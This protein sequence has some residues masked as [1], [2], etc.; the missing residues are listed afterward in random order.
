MV[1]LSLDTP[2]LAAKYDVVGQRQ[3]SHGKLLINDLGI[4]AGEHVLDVGTGTGLLAAYVANIVGPSGKVAA[5]DP[6]PLR[7]ELAKK[8][9]PAQL[10]VSVGNAEDLSAFPPGSFDVVY[11]NSVIHWILDKPRVLAEIRRVLKPGGRVGFTTAAKDR[12]HDVE[13]IRQQALREAGLTERVSASDGIPFKV[14]SDDVRK[15]FEQGG[16]R[17]KQIEVRTIVDYQASAADVHEASLSSSFGNS[18][19]GSLTDAERQRVHAVFAAEL[20]KRRD[21]KGI[22]LERHLIFAVAEKADAS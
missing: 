18:H 14:T 13:L 20:D 12:P 17:P 1:S 3:F 15:L 19:L 4:K 5:I 22:R 8:K 2:E 21:A 10:E 6:L 11:L 7:I 9:A 16:F